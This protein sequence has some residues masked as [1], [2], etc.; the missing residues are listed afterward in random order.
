[1]K[2]KSQRPYKLPEGTTYY[3]HLADLGLKPL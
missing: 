1:M 2:R 3:R